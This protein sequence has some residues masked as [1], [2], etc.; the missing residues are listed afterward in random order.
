MSY[1]YLKVKLYEEER[2]VD[3]GEVKRLKMERNEVEKEKQNEVVI[4]SCFLWAQFISRYRI[5]F[6]LN[7][8]I[9]HLNLWLDCEL[10]LLISQSW[11]ENWNYN[12]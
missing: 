7:K 6:D 9:S 5:K 12:W 11:S 1:L 10:K 3:K 8:E 2:Q 4:Q